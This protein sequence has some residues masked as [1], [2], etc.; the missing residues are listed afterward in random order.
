[1]QLIIAG[2]PTFT[3]SQHLCQVLAPDRH[4]LTQVLTGGARSSLA[5][6]GPGSTW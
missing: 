1:M 5:I 3:D 2:S 6:A 4:R